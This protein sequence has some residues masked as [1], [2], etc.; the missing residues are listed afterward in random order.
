MVAA[1]DSK[2]IPARGAG[3]NPA[4]GTR[5]SEI[6]KR[7]TNVTTRNGIVDKETQPKRTGPI[8]GNLNCF[9]YGKD[10]R[11]TG[12]DNVPFLKRQPQRT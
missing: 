7:G 6:S 11:E 4:G 8:P 10:E 1:M 9:C 3:S 12:H 5:V 2:S